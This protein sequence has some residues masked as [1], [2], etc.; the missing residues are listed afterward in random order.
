MGEVP[1]HATR[2]PRAK[3]ADERRLYH[4]LAIKSLEAR[5]LVGEVQ[6]VAAVFGQNS[7][8]VSL[9]YINPVEVKVA[10]EDYE[11]ALSLLAAADKAE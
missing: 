9:N 3:H 2:N 11:D 1:L 4:V 10:A 8:Y 7:S 6:Q 5:R